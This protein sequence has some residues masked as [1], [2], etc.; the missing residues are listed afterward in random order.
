MMTII[1]YDFVLEIF[2]FKS[3][4]NHISSATCIATYTDTYTGPAC[5]ASYIDTY[6]GPENKYIT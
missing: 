6:M 4:S 2:N 3:S 5:I 1:G